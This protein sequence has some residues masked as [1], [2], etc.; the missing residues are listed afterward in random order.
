[1]STQD[2][3]TFFQK[4]NDDS[5]LKQRVQDALDGRAEAA[6]FEIVDIAA[7]QGCAFTATELREYLT[8]NETDVELTEDQL[9]GAAGGVRMIR[10]LNLAGLRKIRKITPD[11]LR[12]RKLDKRIG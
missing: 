11:L 12:A 10:S 3:T 9:A 7:A 2:I 8:S 1:M 6:A 5:D 4:V